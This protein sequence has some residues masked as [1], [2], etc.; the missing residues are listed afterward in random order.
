MGLWA[1]VVLWAAAIYTVSDVPNLRISDEF[2]NFVLRKAAHITEYFILTA[3]LARAIA[4][5]WV[6]LS[7]K[8]ILSLAAAFSVLYAISDE[9]H[10]SF[11]PG[12]WGTLKDVLVDSCGIMI[13]VLIYRRLK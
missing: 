12:R 4:G 13:F 11:I 7:K 10:Q 5:T 2:W 6:D 9:I 8:S 1:P 3:L